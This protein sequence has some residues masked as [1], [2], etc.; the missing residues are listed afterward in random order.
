MGSFNH[1][2]VIVYPIKN[3]RKNQGTITR[4]ER[5]RERERERESERERDRD[6]CHQ[7]RIALEDAHMSS[8]VSKTMVK[9]ELSFEQLEGDTEL[10]SHVN[11]NIE[12]F[13]LSLAV[14][15]NI[16]KT[17]RFPSVRV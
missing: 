15:K 10:P 6:G 14:S 2:K 9:T 17:Q 7:P 8:D 16:K 1:N 13:L 5:E 11:L 3:R 4:S 12:S